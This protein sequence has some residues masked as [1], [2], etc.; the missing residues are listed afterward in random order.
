MPSE[1]QRAGASLGIR[2]P[3]SSGGLPD[4]PAACW[5]DWNRMAPRQILARGRSPRSAAAKALVA[6]P[7]VSAGAPVPRQIWS[8]VLLNAPSSP[9]GRASAALPR[10]RPSAWTRSRRQAADGSSVTPKVCQLQTTRTHPRRVARMAPRTSTGGLDLGFAS[11]ARISS[12]RPPEEGGVKAGART[13]QCWPASILRT[14]AQIWEAET[15]AWEPRLAR[16]PSSQLVHGR[17]ARSR[18]SW[19]SSACGE[20]STTVTS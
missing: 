12:E 7:Q 8:V 14:P 18:L 15:C 9:R 11:G 10:S 1:G 19:S 5:E 20:G 4:P 2:S 13:K 3:S 16:G 6:C 17:S